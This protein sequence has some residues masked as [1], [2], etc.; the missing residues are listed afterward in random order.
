MEKENPNSSLID[1]YSD[2]E[3]IEIVENPA[4]CNNSRM[5]EAAIV[6]ALNRELITDYQ[7]DELL[8]GNISVLEYNPNNL[9]DKPNVLGY[10]NN[11]KK[12]FF[13]SIKESNIKSGL[14]GIFLGIV[15]ILYGY[16][17]S[18]NHIWGGFNLHF[19]SILLGGLAI[20]VGLIIFVYGVWEKFKR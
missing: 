7:A 15:L 20:L 8:N 14:Y 18:T 1:E 2:D 9:G 6:T 16:F 4:K 3:L 12:S 13:D 17:R 19:G 11:S 5:Y 10:E